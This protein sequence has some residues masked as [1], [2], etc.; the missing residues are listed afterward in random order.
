[1]CYMCQERFHLFKLNERLE[2][3][4]DCLESETP[5]SECENHQVCMYELEVIRNY[6]VQ[7][8]SVKDVLVTNVCK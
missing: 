7:F 4:K 6:S 3:Q 5:Y 1:M 2:S 8:A